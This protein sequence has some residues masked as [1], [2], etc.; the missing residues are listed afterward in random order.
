MSN[1]NEQTDTDLTIAAIANGI[2]VLQ[3]LSSKTR[4]IVYD[5]SLNKTKVY[6]HTNFKELNVQGTP[7][8]LQNHNHDSSYSAL[9]HNH[10]IS[11]INKQYEEEETYQEE[12]EFEE[13]ETYQE[14]E[15]DGQGNISLINKTKT[16][17][18]TRIVD[19]T[20]TITKT[21]PLDT[22]LSEKANTNHTH[23]LSDITDYSTINLDQ[24]F[25]EQA[26][27]QALSVKA[28]ANHTHTTSEITFD[29]EEEE[30]GEVVE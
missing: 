25:T 20:R 17:N 5:Q 10:D 4:N 1:N 15:D 23:S 9:N 26:L 30:D 6:G 24:Y 19:K 3:S 13:E 28:D 14:E 12:E 22:L 8:A 2:S 7:V 18:K 21:K 29:F 16:V 11:D 27:N